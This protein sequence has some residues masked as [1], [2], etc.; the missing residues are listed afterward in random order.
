MSQTFRMALLHCPSYIHVPHICMC[1]MHVP[2][3]CM[4]TSLWAVEEMQYTAGHCVDAMPYYA[5]IFAGQPQ[6][7]L[8]FKLA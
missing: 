2:H 7:Q 3:I 5:I 6:P 4:C 1:Y 8:E